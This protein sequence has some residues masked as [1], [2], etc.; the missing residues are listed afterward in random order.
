MQTQRIETQKFILS[1]YT[2]LNARAGYR[3]YGN[4]AEVSAMVW[5]ALDVQH[6]EHPFGQLAGRRVMGILSYKF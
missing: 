2:L 5:N 6:R 4:R 1:A 3:F